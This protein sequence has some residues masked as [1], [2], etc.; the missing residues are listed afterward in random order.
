MTVC[1]NYLISDKEFSPQSRVRGRVY[2]SLVE[3]C[4]FVKIEGYDYRQRDIAPVDQYL[5]VTQ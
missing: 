4:R 1:T 3:M 2:S 5:S